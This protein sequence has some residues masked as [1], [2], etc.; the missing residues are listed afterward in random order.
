MNRFDRGRGDNRTGRDGAVLRETR[1]GGMG[2][3]GERRKGLDRVR[4]GQ[5][6]AEM[7]L[8]C[9]AIDEV[10]REGVS[11]ERRDFA[12][13]DGSQGGTWRKAWF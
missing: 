2:K 4:K 3:D 13:T 5:S 9:T 10:V 7:K 8:G 6:E 12:S 11:G 1:L